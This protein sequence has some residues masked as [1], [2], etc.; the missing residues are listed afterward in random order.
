MHFSWDHLCDQNTRFYCCFA[1][2]SLGFLVLLRF[3]NA[4]FDR[5]FDPLHRR[6]GPPARAWRRTFPSCGV[7][8][9]QAPTL[10][11]ESLPATIPQSIV[12]GRIL[13]GWM[14][15]VVRPT[16]LPRSAIVLRPST[17]LALHKAM[18]KRKYRMLFP[19]NRRLTVEPSIRH[20]SL[21]DFPKTL[22]C[23]GLRS[24]LG[25]LPITSSGFAFLVAEGFADQIV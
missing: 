12:V 15:L 10:D 13:A 25:K 23:C 17:L 11:R 19:P 9:L 1:H 18:S 5:S 8:S 4:P 16:R 6:P 20:Q 7:N 21:R 24:T 3:F 2:D 14:A 22:D